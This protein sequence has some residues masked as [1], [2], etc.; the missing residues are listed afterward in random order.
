MISIC[1]G[2]PPNGLSQARRAGSFF[3]IFILSLIRRGGVR[4]GAAGLVI[5]DDTVDETHNNYPRTVFESYIRV[6][7]FSNLSSATSC[8]SSSHTT[9]RLSLTMTSWEER[10]DFES[11]PY[12]LPDEDSE[13][14]K[15]EEVLVDRD[16]APLG[17][18]EIRPLE[19]D[20]DIF[21]KE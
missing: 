1:E 12:I 4:P 21:K 2:S 11:F 8:Y 20:P 17:K 19:C 7:Y 14:V 5:F 9:V 18:R 10:N 13:E 3:R 15:P 6:Q 16:G